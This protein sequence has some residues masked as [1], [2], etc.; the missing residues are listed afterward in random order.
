M[1]LKQLLERQKD[2]EV[3][4]HVWTVFGEKAKGIFIAGDQA[5]LGED[6]KTLEQLRAAIDWYADQLGG[7]V[8]WEKK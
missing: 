4:F 3:P 7:K 6:Y 2:V 1:K 8:K 5:S